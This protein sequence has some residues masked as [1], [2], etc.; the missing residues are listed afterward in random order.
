MELGRKGKGDSVGRSKAKKVWHS[1]PLLQVVPR[2]Q[3][4]V[5]HG[6]D[7][8]VLQSPLPVQH[9]PSLE[10]LLLQLLRGRKML[11]RWKPVTQGPTPSDSSP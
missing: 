10:Q 11:I 5:Y 3:P 8:P 2:D 9:P 1:R 4:F 6:P 7:H